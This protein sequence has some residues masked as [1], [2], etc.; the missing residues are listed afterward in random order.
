MGYNMTTNAY[1]RT[2]MYPFNPFA[3]EWM[4]AIESLGLKND[5]ETDNFVQ[6]EVVPKEDRQGQYEAP[7]LTE[8]EKMKL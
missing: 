4:K 6:Y 8:N 7:T 5:D 2:G 3:E 1:Q